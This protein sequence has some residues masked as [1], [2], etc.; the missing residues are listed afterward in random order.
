MQVLSIRVTKQDLDSL[1]E[2]ERLLLLQLGHLGND[3][4]ILVKLSGFL[5][6]Q[7]SDG[8]P[9]VRAQM[10]MFMMVTRILGSKMWEGWDMIKRCYLEEDELQNFPIHKIGQS[11]IESLREVFEKMDTKIGRNKRNILEVLR[12]SEFHYDQSWF[13]RTLAEVPDEFSSC[14]LTQRATGNMFFGISEDFV[15]LRLLR[16]TGKKSVEEAV[17]IVY[18][19]L[20]PVY[21]D[22]HVL[23]AAL[24]SALLEKAKGPLPAERLE[25]HSVPF[26]S[27]VIPFFVD[28]PRAGS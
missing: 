11:A 14:V 17:G 4:N 8:K 20:L 25:V 18:D 10:G 15:S 19:T 6:R 2:K 3:L 27:V 21:A 23:I 7:S 22:F 1:S 9:E 5:Q 16:L 12:N 24:H 28:D 26:D 13:E